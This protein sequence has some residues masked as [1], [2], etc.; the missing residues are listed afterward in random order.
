MRCPL[1]DRRGRLVG[2]AHLSRSAFINRV[3]G[4]VATVIG[5]SG[6]WHSIV[7]GVGSH[8]YTISDP[9]DIEPLVAHIREERPAVLEAHRSE[10]MR[11]VQQL[12]NEIVQLND[13]RG[14]IVRFFNRHK[15]RGLRSRIAAAYSNDKAFERHLDWVID[16]IAALPNS[17]ELA[18]ATAELDVVGRL[19]LLPDSFFVFN[20]VRLKANRKIRF[21][22]NYLQ[23]AQVDHLVLGPTGVFTIE[24][25]CWSRATAEKGSHHDP[26]DQAS[27]AGYLCYDLLKQKFGTTRV[28]S[29]IAH[30]GSLPP[31]PA[32]TK[33]RTA[34]PEDLRSLIAGWNGGR[35]ELSPERIQE[36]RSFFE[37]RVATKA[38]D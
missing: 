8:G 13:S 24:T 9:A 12:S 2:E 36:L 18:G 21:D 25:K 32:D 38:T 31:T 26:F 23:S 22:G 29:V 37:Y 4:I 27:R 35:P 10:T 1:S 5:Q 20:D 30:R 28:H 34:R 17:P 3:G 15:V 6:A 11:S 16:R 33:V 14:R 7:A 19:E